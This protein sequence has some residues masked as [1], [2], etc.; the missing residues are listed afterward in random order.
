MKSDNYFKEVQIDYL[1]RFYHETIQE[2]ER[3]KKQ[4]VMPI[5]QGDSGKLLLSYRYIL[6]DNQALIE[7]EVQRLYKMYFQEQD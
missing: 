2:I 4:S 1:N 6:E 7:S 3:C 5:F